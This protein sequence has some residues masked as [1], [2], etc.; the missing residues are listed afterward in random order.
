MSRRVIW[1]QGSSDFKMYFRFA[2][3][4]WRQKFARNRIDPYVMDRRLF[5]VSRCC[6]EPVQF[7][8]FLTVDIG[9]AL[10]A[11]CMGDDPRIS[12]SVHQYHLGTCVGDNTALPVPD[13]WWSRRYRH[14]GLNPENWRS[15][16][17]FHSWKSVAAHVASRSFTRT[18]VG[19]VGLIN[20]G[21]NLGS[22]SPHTTVLEM[23]HPVA[24]LVWYIVDHITTLPKTYSSL[25]VATKC[26]NWPLCFRYENLI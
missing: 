2:D 21:K 5:H 16:S 7:G 14:A 20:E 3:H 6:L 24:S 8:L 1:T 15:I 12:V 17:R 10:V 26:H 23:R 19:S 18:C 25:Y 22:F 9:I 4:F 13:V 11:P